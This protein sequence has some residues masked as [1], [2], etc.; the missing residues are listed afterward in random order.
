[1]CDQLSIVFQE[2]LGYLLRM[3]RISY[4]LLKNG[5]MALGAWFPGTMRKP[6]LSIPLQI[7]DFHTIC[8]NM[9]NRMF[10]GDALMD[11]RAR[12]PVGIWMNFLV[13]NVY[14]DPAVGVY[15]SPDNFFLVSEIPAQKIFAGESF[16]AI[17]LNSHVFNSQFTD[18]QMTWAVSGNINLNV[19]ISSANVAEI[20]TGSQSWSGK[21]QITFTATTPDGEQKT[22]VADFEIAG[23]QMIY[24]SDMD[25]VSATCSWGTI[26][27]DLSIDGNTITIGGVVYDKGIGTHAQSEIVYQLN[28]AYDLF[29]CTFGIDDEA[30]GSADFQVCRDD[31]LLF[32]KQSTASR[33]IRKM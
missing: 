19:V 33:R 4:S 11:L 2:L 13:F 30:Y 32:T 24:L 17:D 20:T 15:T 22:I 18:D 9:L 29:V 26:Q 12:V 3:I 1:M 31:D 25:W 5:A 14:G 16:K 28:R 8:Q 21:E 23:S 10:V 27:K 7:S 6:M